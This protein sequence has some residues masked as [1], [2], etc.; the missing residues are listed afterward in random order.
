MSVQ[1]AMM[2]FHQYTYG[3]PVV[4]HNDHKPLVATHTKPIACASPRIQRMLLR[5][6]NYNYK[7]VHVPGKDLHLADALSRA[8]SEPI[9]S[10]EEVEDPLDCI[11]PVIVSD[12]TEAELNELQATTAKDLQFSTLKETVMDGWPE[13]KKDCPTILTPFWDYRDEITVCQDVLLKGQTLMIPA[14]G[15]EN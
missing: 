12:L 15:G 4:V 2:K 3:R 7:F 8:C 11:F 13:F 6:Q 5:L 1:F 14:Q 10:E 9:P